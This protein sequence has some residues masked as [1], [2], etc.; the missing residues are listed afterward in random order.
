MKRNTHPVSAPTVFT[1]SNCRT[2]IV[3]VSTVPASTHLDLCSN[4]HPVYTG[5]ATTK[6]SGSRI[7]AFNDRYKVKK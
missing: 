2:E 7:D 4:C 6:V 5:K 3:I 1:C